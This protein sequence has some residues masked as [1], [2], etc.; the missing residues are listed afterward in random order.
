MTTARAF[1]LTLFVM[2]ASAVLVVGWSGGEPW[3]A[4]AFV[5]FFASRVARWA[6][7]HPPVRRRGDDAIG[8]ANRFIVITAAGWLAAGALALVAALRGEGQEWLYVAPFFIVMGGLNSY[9][10]LHGRNG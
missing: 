2:G 5:T 4:A 3:T 1:W 9:V 8:R 7:K 6:I 10:L